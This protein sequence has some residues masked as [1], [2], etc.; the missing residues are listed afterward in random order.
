MEESSEKRRYIYF[1]LAHIQSNCRVNG[2]NLLLIIS[3]LT[4]YYF[5]KMYCWDPLNMTGISVCRSIWIVCLLFWPNFRFTNP[6]SEAKSHFSELTVIKQYTSSVSECTNKKA[7]KTYNHCNLY[8]IF[9]LLFIFYY[10][11]FFITTFFPLGAFVTL[12]SSCLREV[13]Q[14]CC[15]IEVVHLYYEIALSFLN[16]L[17]V[18]LKSSSSK[19][20]NILKLFFFSIVTANAFQ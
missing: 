4:L 17:P 6:N 9:I 2:H 10:L 5:G 18:Q 14:T 1:G 8:N 3:T 7:V 19:S 16:H 11:F 13:L 20:F 12:D 15:I